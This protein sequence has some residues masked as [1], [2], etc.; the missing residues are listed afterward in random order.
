MVGLYFWDW[1]SLGGRGGSTWCPDHYGMPATIDTVDPDVVP[2]VGVTDWWSWRPGLTCTFSWAGEFS[3]TVRPEEWRGYAAAGLAIAILV[4]LVLYA[5]VDAASLARVVSS[6]PRCIATVV[7]IVVVMTF[8]TGARGWA[9]ASAA[10]FVFAWWGTA[11]I[12]IR[13][14]SVRSSSVKTE[15]RDSEGT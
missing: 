10:L 5:K 14:S 8:T 12:L 9:I 2:F 7:V 15:A 4:L 3:V 11:I 1:F 6:W 13:R